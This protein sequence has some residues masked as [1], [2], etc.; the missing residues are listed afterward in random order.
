MKKTLILPALFL[1]VL[2]LPTTTF[3]DQAKIATIGTIEPSLL[4]RN[5]PSK[6]RFFIKLKDAPAYVMMAKGTPKRKSAV[7]RQQERFVS[8][9]KQDIP[10]IKLLT[11]FQT[12][13]N[14]LVIE[15]EP[16]EVSRLAMHP[17]VSAIHRSYDLKVHIEDKKPLIGLDVLTAEYGIENT[18]GEG[19]NVAIIDTGVDYTHPDLGGC[20]GEECKVIGGY[21]F[22]NDDTD[23][24]DDHFH[25]THVAGIV[26]ANGEVTGI[27]PAANIYALKACSAEGL[28]TDYDVIRSIEW[29]MDPDGDPDTDDAADIMNLSLGSADGTPESPLSIAVNTASEAGIVMVTSAGNDGP[30]SY[31]IGSPANAAEAITVAAANDDGTIAEFSSRGFIRE[32]GYLKPDIS[33]PGVNVNAPVLDGAYG[34]YSGTSMAAPVV[35]GVAAI[36]KQNYPEASVAEIKSRLINTAIDLGVESNA[37][38]NGMVNANNAFHANLTAD[39]TNISLGWLRN[40]LG[41]TLSYDITLTNHA[42][43]EQTV[44]I[45]F[46][47]GDDNPITYAVEREELTIAAGGRS[48][49][50]L[51]VTLPDSLDNFEGNELLAKLNATANSTL[52]IPVVGVATPTIR[53]D[54]SGINSYIH[55]IFVYSKEQK[56]RIAE[57]WPERGAA[58]VIF[59][60]DNGDYAITAETWPYYG[61]YAEVRNIVLFDIVPAYEPIV[62]ADDVNLIPVDIDLP[63]QNGEKIEF[64]NGV[65]APYE[66]ETDIVVPEY[67]LDLGKGIFGVDI[68]RQW[69]VTAPSE[70]LFYDVTVLSKE[71]TNFGA[72]AVPQVSL[73]LRLDHNT[74][75]EGR[76]L[77]SYQ[78]DDVYQIRH[79]FANQVGDKANHFHYSTGEFGDTYGVASPEELESAPSIHTTYTLANN[80]PDHGYQ[81]DR[82]AIVGDMRIRTP[83]FKVHNDQLV[84]LNFLSTNSELKRIPF[85]EQKLDLKVGFAQPYFKA[86]FIEKDT[87]YF[88]SYEAAGAGALFAD[89]QLNLVEA[90]LDYS[91]RGN[92]NE[93][94]ASTF[95][96]DVYVDGDSFYRPKDIAISPDYDQANFQFSGFMIDAETVNIEVDLAFDL[97]LED[98]FPPALESFTLSTNGSEHTYFANGNGSVE[99]SF[100]DDSDITTLELAYRPT[101]S[102][103][104]WQTV[105]ASV[106]GSSISAT[107]DGLS[108]GGYDLRLT[109]EDSQGNRF[110]QTTSPA[111]IAEQGCRYD[112]N[113][114]GTWDVFEI[115]DSDGDGVNDDED[116]FPNDP[117]E[118]VDTDGDGVGDNADAFPD[119]A[120]EWLDSDGDGIGDNAD[121]TPNGELT[122]AK[123][124]DL[125]GDGKADLGFRRPG[126]GTWYVLNSGDD[127]YNSSRQDGIQRVQFGSLATDIPVNG[128]FDGD[129][130]ADIAVRR[131]STGVWYIK[132]SSGE[133]L[134]TGN[135]DGI[136]RKR[137]GSL[138]EDIPIPADYDGDGITDLAVRRPSTQTWY[139]LNSSGIDALTHHADGITR[140]R[141]GSKQEDIPVPA[142]YDG[143]GKADLA[144]RRPSNKTSYIRN[145][146]G[147]DSLTG[148][149]DGISRK[150]FGSLDEDIPVPADFDGDGKAD[151]AVRRPSTQ[152]WFV[153]NSSGSNYNSGRED[154]IQRVRFGT[155]PEDI[156][157]V[158]DYDGDGYADFAVRR[159][160][161]KIQ[162]ILNSSGIDAITG[163]ED[164]ITRKRFGSLESDIPLAVP[165]QTKTAML[166][167]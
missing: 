74:V 55:G 76:A 22:V 136:T 29:A 142:D 131:P 98:G 6:N 19:V 77:L 159:P 25:G 165:M 135:A 47:P 134:I 37:Q 38:G 68:P 48:T 63:L 81:M 75:S 110:T 53:V 86:K 113:C 5:K 148:H 56:T 143:D 66:L 156:P 163:N 124:F 20:F 155:R 167:L 129:L 120:S 35:A 111:F 133:D 140:L 96:N 64:N 85:H 95:N 40:N 108:D 132:N 18:N 69:W 54:I 138:A 151:I 17:E 33:A 27:A 102:D 78:S 24:I 23:P 109:A 88:I 146:S 36:L 141:F 61:S 4:Q 90:E 150:R 49:F 62:I 13:Q 80:L 122:A 16:G 50:S 58:E 119:D 145:S 51:E 101:S 158:A 121:T 112:S 71:A 160:S 45:A 57:A 115:P 152:Y 166:G 82:V 87:G 127:N 65:I 30:G 21:D 91:L 11:S 3:A 123:A 125:N 89:N 15:A 107:F 39:V 52:T 130:V 162:Y 103:E 144:V 41:E 8:Q 92:G 153:F 105:D 73:P 117:E 12:Y 100:S 42:A 93:I 157:I 14:L 79:I 114:D 70:R 43:E 7:L 10:N 46:D 26:A 126:T 28:C 154:G 94:S 72:F 116:A 44:A 31:R 2:S 97:A 9:L 106:D 32:T 34:S 149:A 99:A 139:I 128:D 59:P 137:F 1:S 104:D 60:V 83:E 84:L 118:T 67:G 161:T 147:V 164:G